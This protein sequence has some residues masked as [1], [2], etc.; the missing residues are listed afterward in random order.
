MKASCFKQKKLNNEK[1]SAI[2]CYDYPSARLVALT[3]IHCILVGDTL[4]MTMHGFPSTVS[5]TIEMMVLHTK[6]VSRGLGKQFLISDLPFLS[7]RISLND[8]MQSVK[9][10]LQAGAHAIKLEGGDADACKTIS[11]LTQ[12][13]IAVVGHI[14]L[15]PQ[16]VHK[17]SG[18]RLQGK[19]KEDAE[20]LLMEAKN[21]EKSGAIALVLECIPSSL[22]KTISQELSIPTIGIGA[23]PYTDG[24]ILVWHDLLG[25]QTDLLKPKFLK[26]YAELG[27]N[28]TSAINTY[29]HEVV[30]VHYPSMEHSYD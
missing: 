24:Q 17:L 3:N 13:G 26:H 20:R 9:Q 27:E 7:Y 28:I 14:G 29:H 8:T 23:G 18:Y 6:A 15:T 1:I 30:N 12:A 21:I 10:L 22:A 4:A 5:A 25:I 11:Y 2:T 19:T 16:S